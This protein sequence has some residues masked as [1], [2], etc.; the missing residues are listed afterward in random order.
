MTRTCRLVVVL[1]Q[2]N[3]D[4]ILAGIIA[5]AIARTRRGQTE[6]KKVATLPAFVVEDLTY[7]GVWRDES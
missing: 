4:E 2:V 6:M 3:V 7:R 1:H 5:G